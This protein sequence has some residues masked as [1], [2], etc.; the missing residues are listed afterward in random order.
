[1]D[2]RQRTPDWLLE[3]IA[4]GELPPDELAAARRQLE[5]EP[6]GRERLAALEA[7]NREILAALPPAAMADRI[8]QRAAEQGAPARRASRW[9]GVAIAAPALAAA[10]L[11]I[12]LVPTSPDDDSR[13]KG[14]RPQ[15]VIHRL[16]EGQIERLTEQAVV[17]AGDRIQISYVAAGRRFGCVFSIDGR[18]Q[19]TQHLA[20]PGPPPAQLTPAGEVALPTSYELDDAPDFE[21]F[22][23]VACS[24]QY[25]QALVIEEARRIAAGTAPATELVGGLPAGCEQASLVLSKVA[26]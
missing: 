7:S 23:F 14:L 26:P 24:T 20:A 25:N 12:W 11:L 21:R 5:S 9:L 1:M 22:V 15:V 4:L 2:G 6:D 19:L 10:A 18:R 17:R 13:L 8:R 16:V 3:R